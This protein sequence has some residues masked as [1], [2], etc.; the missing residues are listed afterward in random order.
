MVRKDITFRCDQEA[1]AAVHA[2]YRH[3]IRHELEQ[4]FICRLAS[5]SSIEVIGRYFALACQG[6]ESSSKQ[7][8]SS[9]S[10]HVLE[11]IRFFGFVQKGDRVAQSLLIVG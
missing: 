10:V 4:L 1:S 7:M 11:R 6:E 3:S 5:K 9:C 8:K 2:Q